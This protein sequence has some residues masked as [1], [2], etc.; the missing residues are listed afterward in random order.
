LQEIHN[1]LEEYRLEAQ[2]EA[3]EINKSEKLK[4]LSGDHLKRFLEDNPELK[5]GK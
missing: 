3:E 2:K 4:L 1:A 5:E